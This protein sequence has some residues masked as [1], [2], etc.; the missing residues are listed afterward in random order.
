[1][2]RLLRRRLI[3]R[4]D[5]LAKVDSLVLVAHSASKRD[6]LKVE[7]CILAGGLS[8]RMGSD[9]SRIR[10]G[11]S[12]ML[13]L[14][15][16]VANK[17]GLKVRTLRRDLVARS[18]PL[19]GIYSALKMTNADTVVFLACDMPFVRAEMIN[20]LTAAAKADPGRLVFFRLGLKLGF[21]FLMPRVFAGEIAHRIE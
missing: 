14:I 21:P 5:V 13:G 3:G 7:I 19:G 15:R 20:S 18:G 10:F 1:M 8:S 12:T 16:A 17:T 11:R 2:I 4:L 9:K 6:K